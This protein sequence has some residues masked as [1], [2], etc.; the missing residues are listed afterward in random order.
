MKP[1]AIVLAAGEGRRF[2]SPKQ[3]ALLRGRPLLQHV[4]DAANAAPGLGDVLLVLG[5]HADEIVA[6]V[7]G[8][9]A[10]VVRCDEWREGMAAS[11]RAGAA[12]LPSDAEAALIL[13]G[14]QPLVTPALIALVLDH[15][16]AEAAEG[17]AVDAVRISYDNVPGHPVLLGRKILARIPML[18]GDVGARDL[19]SAAEVR[20]VESIDTGGGVDVDTP[21]QLE[22]LIDRTSDPRA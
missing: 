11:L 20:L 6:K 3:L 16:A 15:A 21:E 5:A 8:G 10:R 13:L 17:N 2:G 9:K 1:A 14:D 19:L 4:L 22:A 18:R 7:C 12:A